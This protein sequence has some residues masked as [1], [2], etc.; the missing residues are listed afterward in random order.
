MSNSGSNLRWGATIDPL[1]PS[2]QCLIVGKSGRERG[3]PLSGSRWTSAS[4][5]PNVLLVG[6]SALK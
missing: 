3:L 1:I 5:P 4:L 2:L 6:F